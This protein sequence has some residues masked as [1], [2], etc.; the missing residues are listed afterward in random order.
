MFDFILLED[1]EVEIISNETVLKTEDNACLVSSV[2]TNKRLILLDSPKD[3]E[4]FRVGKE[5]F[6]SV[7]KEVILEILLDDIKNIIDGDEFDTYQL[8]DDSY[9][10]LADLQVKNYIRAVKNAG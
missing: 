6:P 7:K 4:K 10:Y 5:I 3:L 2:I 9:F 8:V 1:E